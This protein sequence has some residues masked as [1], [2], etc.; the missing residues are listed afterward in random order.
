M[1]GVVVWDD[2]GTEIQMNGNSFT[3][4]KFTHSL[5]KTLFNEHCGVDLK[6]RRIEI[7]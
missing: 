7:L 6:V 1:T 3:A 5:R 2:E 4:T